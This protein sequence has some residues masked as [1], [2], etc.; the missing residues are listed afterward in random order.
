MML[1]QLLATTRVV[2]RV[3]DRAGAY[4]M[5]EIPALP[6]LGAG[7]G[8]RFRP[9]AGA[10]TQMAEAAMGRFGESGFSNSVPGVLSGSVKEACMSALSSTALVSGQQVGPR[11]G[12]AGG[13]LAAEGARACGV[14][15]GS[16]RS[17]GAK[18][19]WRRWLGKLW[20]RPGS[21]TGQP[22]T[23][24][25]LPL[26]RVEA[27]AEVKVVRNDLRDADEELWGLTARPA[28]AAG[29]SGRG[30]W[31]A[32]LRAMRQWFDGL[33]TRWAGGRQA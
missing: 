16:M 30:G 31:W 4:R 10:R 18:V 2:R 21:E 27:L 9:G 5:R 6:P 32:G 25:E 7:A 11:A 12:M 23:Q 29:G 14:E 20:R 1:E 33:V 28:R 22:A 3:G 19:G 15:P 13:S 24:M 26:R 8:P 17:S